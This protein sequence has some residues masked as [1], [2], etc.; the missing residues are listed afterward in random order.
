MYVYT[1]MYI[2]V[3]IK[4]YIS[5]FGGQAGPEMEQGGPSGIHQ[6]CGEMFEALP[7]VGKALL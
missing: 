7:M 6:V 1:Y 5:G 2:H 4:I 3:Y